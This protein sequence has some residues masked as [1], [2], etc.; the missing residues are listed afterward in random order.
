ML[1]RDKIQKAARALL[2]TKRIELLLEILEAYSQQPYSDLALQLKRV[3]ALI[4]TRNMI[5]H[6]P[7]V[8][9]LYETADGSFLHRQVISHVQKEKEID[10]AELRRFANESEDVSSALWAASLAVFK[11]HDEA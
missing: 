6:N 5:A 4:G 8:L 9:E 3:Q 1:P 7:L 2:L 10:L 11:A